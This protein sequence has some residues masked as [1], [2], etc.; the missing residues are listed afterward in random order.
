M[1]YCNIV[2]MYSMEYNL[3]NMLQLVQNSVCRAI[4]HTHKGASVNY[5]HDVCWLTIFGPSPAC[6]VA[7][8]PNNRLVVMDTYRLDIVIE[9]KRRS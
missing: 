8:H 7:G 5:V 6:D 1:T 2:Y 9:L 4:R 3:Q